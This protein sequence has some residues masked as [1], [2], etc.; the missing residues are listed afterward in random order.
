[1]SQ[2]MQRN[3]A[4]KYFMIGWAMFGLGILVMGFA[5][6][7][8]GAALVVAGL[9]LAILFKYPGDWKREPWLVRRLRRR[10]ERVTLEP[11]D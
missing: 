3:P 1:M 11:E 9:A 7:V 6:R 2:W 5:W 8:G 10:D 4:F